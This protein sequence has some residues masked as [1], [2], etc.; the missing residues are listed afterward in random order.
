MALTAMEHIKQTM[1]I[2]TFH[3]IHS[4]S[5]YYAVKDELHKSTIEMRFIVA[6]RLVLDIFFSI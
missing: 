5:K 3:E 6:R 1:A 2:W 4:K